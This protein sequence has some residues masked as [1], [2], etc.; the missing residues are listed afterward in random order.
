MKRCGL[1]LVLVSF[2]T[3]LFLSAAKVRSNTLVCR[4]ERIQEGMTHQQVK[5]VLGPPALEFGGLG[6]LGFADP[7]VS[8]SNPGSTTAVWYFPSGSIDIH[9]DEQGKLT[10]KTLRTPGIDRSAQSPVQRIQAFL[11]M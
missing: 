8:R 10:D 1:P 9:Y 3:L 5:E 6:W 4:L 11:G 2:A 7:Q